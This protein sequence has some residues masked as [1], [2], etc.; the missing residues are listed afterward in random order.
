MAIGFSNFIVEI[1]DAIVAVILNQLLSTYGG[2]V[3]IA[4][5]GIISRSTMVLF[6]TVIGVSTGMQPIAAYNFGARNFIR[7][8]K[9]VKEA[10][11]GVTVSLV[12]WGSAMIFAKPIAKALSTILL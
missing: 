10:T 11:I 12:L 3:A 1:S 7:L 5:V 6:M 8:K 9:V 4:I 2:D